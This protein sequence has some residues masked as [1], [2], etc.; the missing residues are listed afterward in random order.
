MDSARE[1]AESILMM[2]PEARMQ[3]KR[4]LHE[5]YGR[6]DQMNFAWSLFKAPEAPEGMRAFAEKRSPSWVPE[7]LKKGRL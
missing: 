1:T 7:G 3:V 4:I 5:R 2:A 6:V